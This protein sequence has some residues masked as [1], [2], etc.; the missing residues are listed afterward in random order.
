MV[1]HMIHLCDCYFQTPEDV[2]IAA[3]HAVRRFFVAECQRRA[4]LIRDGVLDK[5]STARPNKKRR[6]AA[7]IEA[8]MVGASATQQQSASDK[9]RKWLQNQY[10]LFLDMGVKIIQHGTEQQQV[11][12]SRSLLECIAVDAPLTTANASGI[13]F[14]LF[15]AHFTDFPRCQKNF[16]SDKRFKSYGR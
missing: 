15:V 2:S 7:A 5:G 10:H 13:I 12:C 6:K 11:L 16:K 9:L 3:I 4:Q 1:V 8:E 14:F